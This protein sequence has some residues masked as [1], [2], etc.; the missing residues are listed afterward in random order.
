MDHSVITVGGA[1]RMEK[2][3]HINK[4]RKQIKERKRKEER[5]KP[6]MLYTRHL[7]I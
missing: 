1:G 3:L 5:K 2:T 6:I 4:K 7:S